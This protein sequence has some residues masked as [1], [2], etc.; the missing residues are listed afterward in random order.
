M[1]NKEK[2]INDC[3][4]LLDEWH[5]EKNSIAPQQ[6]SVNSKLEVWWRCKLNH[7][8]KAEIHY[9]VTKKHGCPYCSNN[10]VWT[11]YNDFASNYP[12]L[13]DEWDYSK[14]LNIDPCTIAKK[15]NLKVAWICQHGHTWNASISNRALGTKCPECFK[16]KKVSYAEKAIYYYIKSIFKD[17]IP[18]Y[19]DEKLRKV[20]LDIY[21]PTLK[22]GIEYDGNRYHQN[23]EKDKLKNDIV[24]K[25]NIKLIRVREFG[26]PAMTE[27]NNLFIINRKNNYKKTLLNSI[28]EIFK[29][30]DIDIEVNITRDNIAILNL[31][32]FSIYSG[33]LV[34]KYPNLISEWD[35]E[36]N[37]GL[38]PEKFFSKSSHKVYWKC[39]FGHSWISTIAKRANG[40]CCPYCSNKKILQGFNDLATTNPSLAREWDH[41]KNGDLS[42]IMV[43]QSSNKKVY[44]LCSENHSWNT[45]IHHRNNGSGC[46]YCSGHKALPGYNDFYTTNSVLLK[47]W[48]YKKNVLNPTQVTKH[49]NK[50]ISWKCSLG[51]TWD[52]TISNRLAGTGCPY[53]SN[54]KILIGFNDLE[55]VNPK[56]L[57]EWDYEKNKSITPK[58][59][60]ISSGRKIYW[61]CKEGHSWQAKISHRTI[62]TGCP[63]CSRTKV[64]ANFN[65]LNSTHPLIAVDWSTNNKTKANQYLAGSNRKVLWSCLKC[66]YEYLKSIKNK[67]RNPKCP[68]C[69]HTNRGTY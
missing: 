42:P 37:K 52:A 22:I 39:K 10:K 45:A 63:Y 53:C 18:N 51:H 19:R 1:I 27:R 25:N 43:T 64:L 20:E 57:L 33:D 69:K 12:H 32:E 4:N 31:I 61:K 65:D 21:I 66:K 8:W 11:G 35:Y 40:R 47:D 38:K 44:W 55:T 62:G 28:Y 58:E 50:K 34:E 26:C 68:K 56:L 60:T 54:K 16:G 7:T 48:D 23:L 36:L 49:S 6:V 41:E 13:L 15:C 17:A 14:N 59:V 3:P 46:P 67:V 30:L 5:Y 2:T 29:L 9:R 24:I